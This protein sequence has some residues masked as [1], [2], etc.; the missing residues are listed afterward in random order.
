MQRASIGL[1]CL[2]LSAAASAQAP[3]PADFIKQMDKND[4]GALSKEEM[5]GMPFAADFEKMDANKDS[6]V[7]ASEFERYM[8]NNRPAGGPPPG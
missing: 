4:D 8:K 5:A 3:N 2:L 7:N 6:K 1:V